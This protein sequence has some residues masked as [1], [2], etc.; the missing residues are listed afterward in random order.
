MG[1]IQR[2]DRADQIRLLRFRIRAYFGLFS[3]VKTPQSVKGLL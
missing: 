2:E 3:A 1:M